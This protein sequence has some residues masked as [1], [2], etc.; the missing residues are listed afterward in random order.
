MGY[1]TKKVLSSGSS[2][3]KGGRM[4]KL[5]Y[6]KSLQRG[7]EPIVAVGIQVMFGVCVG[8]WREGP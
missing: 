8:G 1:H 3:L 4:V 6:I 5:D 2:L 7:S